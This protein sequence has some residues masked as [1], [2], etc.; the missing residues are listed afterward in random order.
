MCV[1]KWH[2]GHL[3]EYLPTSRG[4]DEYF[5]IPYSNDMTPRPL[6]HNTEDVEEPATLDNLTPRY[7]EQAI[8]FIERSKDGPFFLYMPHTFPHIP[9]AASPRFRGKSGAGL[10]GDVV[11]EIDW[12]VGEVL[13]A[14]K[15]HGL[16]HNTLVMF[17]S[18]NGPWYQGSPG[19]L[20]GRKGTTYEGGVR[21]PFLARW[22]GRIPKGG[23]PRRG[24]HHR[25]PADGG[26]P[27]RRAAA[28]QARSTA[29]TSG[30][31]SR[32]ERSRSSARRCSTSTTGTCSAP[33]GTAG[34]CTSRAT[35]RSPTAP[36]RRAA[37]STCRSPPRNSTTWRTI[38]TRATTSRR[39]T[40]RWSPIFRRA[41]SACWPT[42]P[43]RSTRPGRQ[44]K[45]GA[46]PRECPPARCPGRWRNEHPPAR[47]SGRRRRG[48]PAGRAAGGAPQ[49]PLPAFAR[50]RPLHPA[51]RPRRAHAE[52][53]KA[54]RRGRA[55]PPGLLRRAHLLAQPRR[56]AHRTVPA[57]QRHARPGPPRLPAQRL[58]PPHPP[59]AARRRLLLRAGGRAAHRRPARPDRLRPRR[60]DRAA[61]R[62]PTWR[63][64]PRSS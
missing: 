8:Q 22:P 14:V 18:D 44:P 50:Y 63:P 42:S 13:G 6:L 52:P 35:T 25:H 36:R 31:C 30:R 38:R 4:F 17:S 34:S 45:R 24:R 16:D 41:S 48:P 49:H 5:G 33:A 59:H 32:A 29:S 46:S 1:G 2:L 27:V 56:A 15:K 62:V 57:L 51:L 37:A 54:R 19:R 23:L 55:V 64:P 7:T 20:R 26:E 3:P 10:Y 60:G 61:A 47:F 43:K 39:R 21:E 12:S 9:L 11:E 58:P 40:P 28:G 53:A